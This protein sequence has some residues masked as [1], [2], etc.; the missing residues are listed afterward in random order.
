MDI[1][2]ESNMSN[3]SFQKKYIKLVGIIVIFLVVASFILL[4]TQNIYDQYMSSVSTSNIERFLITYNPNECTQNEQT[5]YCKEFRFNTY[6][7]VNQYV[8]SKKGITIKKKVDILTSILT[9]TNRNPDS[10]LS[11]T[12]N[13]LPKDVFNE[14]VY[15]IGQM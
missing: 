1:M 7:L 4:F 6:E 10:V 9:I 11:Q 15:A 8:V 5:K 2:Y 12:M 14:E 3:M 13:G